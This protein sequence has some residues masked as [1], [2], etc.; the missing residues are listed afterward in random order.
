M[1]R[2]VKDG[3]RRVYPIAPRMTDYPA[4]VSESTFTPEQLE[5]LQKRKQEFFGEAD[6]SSAR[7]ILEKLSKKSQL[8]KVLLDSL[9]V[10]I[11]VVI[12]N[13]PHITTSDGVQSSGYYSPN[14]NMI[15]LGLSG[16][17]ASTMVHEIMHGMS[18]NYIKSN[19]N[20]EAVKDFI[21]LFEYA[22]TLPELQGEYGLT[23]EYE[24]MSELFS[25]TRFQKKLSNARPKK[26]V[27]PYKNLFKQIWDTILKFF[28]ISKPSLFEQS[29]AVASNIINE[30]KDWYPNTLELDNLDNNVDYAKIVNDFEG[31]NFPNTY[32][33]NTVS[34]A[35]RR[36]NS[37]YTPGEINELADTIVGVFRDIVDYYQEEYTDL[38]REDVIRKVTP[39]KIFQDVREELEA[40]MQEFSSRGGLDYYVNNQRKMLDNYND[41]VLMA[42]PVITEDEGLMFGIQDYQTFEL[43][44][45]SELDSGI[46]QDA[47]MSDNDL[48]HEEMVT[49]G[50]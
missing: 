50:W 37:V 39:I 19:P 30:A 10:D 48:M 36:L 2:F 8:A 34:D 4:Q 49:D 32:N 27:K 47:D 40:N 44:M 20:N 11:P 43:K 22:K 29:F 1:G 13:T 38:S 16:I 6:T 18:I 15:T 23:N 25:N 7:E 33:G 31:V 35:L 14:S 45:E 9:P 5:A 26:G 21:S 42:L 3:K 46:S 12:E 28:G 17:T 41:L 24:F